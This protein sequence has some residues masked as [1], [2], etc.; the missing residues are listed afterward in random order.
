[1]RILPFFVLCQ[2][3]ELYL[4]IFLFIVVFVYCI[5]E[6]WMRISYLFVMFISRKLT[7][8]LIRSLLDALVQ[9]VQITSTLIDDEHSPVIHEPIEFIN[10]KKLLDICAKAAQSFS[11]HLK[12]YGVIEKC[13]LNV[14]HLIRKVEDTVN[15][16]EHWHVVAHELDLLINLF[17]AMAYLGVAYSVLLTPS[18]LDPIA[19]QAAQK[20]CH[21]AVVSVLLSF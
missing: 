18:F 2:I 13:F 1:M 20:D 6:L 12:D 17:L 21:Q 4:Y 14:F 19:M 5:V 11:G 8:K 7:S 15:S 10:E 3:C 16:Q 9:T